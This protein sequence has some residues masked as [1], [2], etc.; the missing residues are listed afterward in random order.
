VLINLL[1]GREQFS[2]PL[3]SNKNLYKEFSIGLQ[4]LILIL[5]KSRISSRD[6]ETQFD[7]AT[8]GESRTIFLNL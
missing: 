3:W 2:I 7:L 4:V 5:S 1:L 6:E 8:Q